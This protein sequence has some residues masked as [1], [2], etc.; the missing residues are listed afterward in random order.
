M[1]RAYVLSLTAGLLAAV[2]ASG[3]E[4]AEACTGDKFEA[5]P[6]AS[7]E[8]Q[9]V[10]NARELRAALD[11]ARGG[12][13]FL[14]AP[15][16]Y[17]A[18]AV[19]RAYESPVTLRSA[20]AAA[21][22]CFTELRLNQAGNIV[23]DGLIFDYRY[24]PG[25]KDF[26]N[27]FSIEQSRN[28]TVSGSVFDGGD[29]GGVGHGRGLRIRN[30]SDIR[31]TDSVFRKW[32]KALSGGSSRNLILRGNEFYNIR[33]DGIALGAIDGLVVE[34]NRLHN[35]RGIPGRDHRDMLQIMRS[36]NRRSTN[37]VIR[38]NVFDM[39]AGDYAQT[40][41][42][43]GDGKNLGDPGLRHQNVV[44]ENNLIYN[45]HTNGISVY[46]ADNLSIRR[47]T[48]IRVRREKGGK[49][50]IPRINVSSGS[51]RV[52]I[53]QNAVAGIT[54]YRQQTDWAVLNNAIIQDERALRPGYYPR[55]FV[56]YATGASCGYHEYGVRPGG[57]VDRLN[58][59][60]TLAE[61]Y[62]SHRGDAPPAAAPGGA[63]TG[64][65]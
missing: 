55:E 1:F 32:W 34:A 60:S 9:E 3:P 8:G 28:I 16:G 50:T 33:S 38:D 39:G 21:P 51:T 25:D 7:A 23:L 62:P 26:A 42:M 53:E 14:L 24:A 15:G 19:K 10:R 48:V 56:V 6:A 30:S 54:G 22:A 11:N 2:T 47:N 64:C 29:N 43:G 57:E 13:I 58:A 12:E 59:G 37:I 18:L 17:G 46:G 41:W 5:R 36:S 63:R 27:R 65:E 45:A 40:I 35:F 61:N 4:A 31:I 44:I 49:I 20:V 52:V